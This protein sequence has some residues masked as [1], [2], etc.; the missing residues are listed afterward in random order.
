MLR[1]SDRGLDDH[2][3]SSYKRMLGGI[4]RGMK[5]NET[6][7]YRTSLEKQIKKI[8]ISRKERKESGM[9]EARREGTSVFP[10]II[11][12]QGGPPTRLSTTSMYIQHLA[13]QLLL[14]R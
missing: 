14:H 9:P 5:A 8:E 12:R 2:S 13:N 4:K 3:N 1:S 11:P 6:S 7:S 10:K